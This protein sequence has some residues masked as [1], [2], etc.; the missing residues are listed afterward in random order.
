MLCISFKIVAVNCCPISLFLGSRDGKTTTGF[1]YPR[2]ELCFMVL[3]SSPL[4]KKAS[5]MYIYGI[6]T[7]QSVHRYIA[8][9]VF[10]RRDMKVIIHL[11][12][13]DPLRNLATTFVAG[14]KQLC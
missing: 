6:P 4:M 14:K 2:L 10:I 3:G 12:S 7:Y 8:S 9:M 5:C 1:F 11:T 13:I